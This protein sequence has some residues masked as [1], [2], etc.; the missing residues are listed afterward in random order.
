MKQVKTLRKLWDNDPNLTVT[1]LGPPGVG[2]TSLGREFARQWDAHCEVIDLTSRLPED[3]GGYP[4]QE[5]G[6]L[7]YATQEWIHR[8]NS[9]E[10]AVLVLD[11]LPAA[12]PAVAVAARQLVLDRRLH[13]AYLGDHVRVL[14]TGN[15]SSDMSGAKSLPAHFRNSVLLMD[16][17]PDLK[18]WVAYYTA[19]NLPEWIPEF[20]TWK[21]SHFSQY[22]QTACDLGA[23]ATPRQWESLGR[24]TQGLSFGD[25][26]MFPIMRGLVGEGTA[27]EALAYL[28]VRDSLVP[29]Q[30]LYENP[31]QA[32]PD[33][34]ALDTADKMMTTVTSLGIEVKRRIWNCGEGGS[35]KMEHTMACAL[36][37]T[38]ALEWVSRGN[39]RD[40]FA[41]GFTHIMD[42]V[43]V[44]YWN[45]FM[46]RLKAS[47]PDVIAEVRSMMVSE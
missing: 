30:G 28:K 46:E 7:R 38:E 20:L 12:A 24:S 6:V 35:R 4:Y 18:D 2:K 34:T 36:Q 44:A 32:Y 23:F 40:Y 26:D 33:P 10:R 14:V 11:D 37:G 42:E 9:A 15:R 17:E 8:L 16:F 22:P 39:S 21:P 47:C 25:N 19:R 5:D 29:P 27:T 3:L 13:D 41:L 31:Q 43:P 45:Q 1:V